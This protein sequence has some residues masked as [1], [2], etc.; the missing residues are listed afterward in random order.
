MLLKVANDDLVSFK[1][2]NEWLANHPSNAI[3]FSETAD[4]WNQIKNA[5]TVNFKELVF[6]EIPDETEIAGSLI[7]ISDRL[8]KITWKINRE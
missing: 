3:I 7:A 5:Y 8:K 6:G 2:N 1:N 4:T